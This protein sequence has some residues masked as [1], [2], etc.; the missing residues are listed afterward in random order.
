M[1]QANKTLISSV[2]DI[3]INEYSLKCELKEDTILKIGKTNKMI[4]FWVITFASLSVDSAELINETAGSLIVVNNRIGNKVSE[5]LRLKGIFFIDTAG[6]AF[7]RGEDF[8]IDV[9]G[10]KQRK[11]NNIL[12]LEKL[13]LEKSGIKLLI[14]F[15]SRPDTLNKN[16][17]DIAALSG[18]SLGYVSK[19]VKKLRGAGYLVKDES[20]NFNIINRN[21]LVQR[22]RID[23]QTSL[24]HKYFIGRYKITGDVHYSNSDSGIYSIY[25]TSGK[26]FE[27]KKGFLKEKITELYLE[28]EPKDFI[29]INRLIPAQSGNLIV[30]GKYWN[31]EHDAMKNKTAPD[32]IVYLDLITSANPRLMEAAGEFYAE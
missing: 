10:R 11:M 9:R 16:Y 8:F 19:F 31:F 5:I 4:E 27:L 18:C 13:R 15:F 22:L 21:E 12:P 1:K 14:T 24:K 3:L 2:L 20:G 6:N 23:Y 25:Y 26:A 32:F 7:I 28:G 30:F 29:K 17:R